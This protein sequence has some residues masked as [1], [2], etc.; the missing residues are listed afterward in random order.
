VCT[1]SDAPADVMKTTA[2]NALES[3]FLDWIINLI[4]RPD[5][6]GSRR[7][8]STRKKI[9]ISVCLQAYRKCCPSK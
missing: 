3:M 2:T 5:S 1:S 9:P 7:R 8:G 4:L 6:G